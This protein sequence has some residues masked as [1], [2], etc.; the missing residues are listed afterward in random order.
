ME[1]PERVAAIDIGFAHTGIVVFEV[2]GEQLVYVDST[3]I[4]S[5]KVKKSKKGVALQ[6]VDR[7]YTIVNGAVAYLKANLVARV[8]IELPTGGA[9]SSRAA[10]C[11][12]IST[13]MT[14]MLPMLLNCPAKFVT[15]RSVKKAATGDE[16]AEKKPIIAAMTKLYPQIL[17]HNK[18]DQEHISDSAGVALVAKDFLLGKEA[19]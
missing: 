14:V 5:K 13:G 6:D 7:I 16:F 15:P 4:N 9:K 18:G 10:R 12:G 8:A 1:T 2:V 19:K 11:L 17:K 3:C